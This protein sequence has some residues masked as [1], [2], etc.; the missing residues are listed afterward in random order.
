MVR[1]Y[2][3]ERPGRGCRA[4][5]QRFQRPEQ[6]VLRTDPALPLLGFW[7]VG[8]VGQSGLLGV[9]VVSMMAPP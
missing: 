5:S 7:W 6:L 2:L 3:V 8:E 9:E 1:A 4:P